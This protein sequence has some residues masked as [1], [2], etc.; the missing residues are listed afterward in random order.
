MWD[1]HC[2]TKLYRK[3]V[4]NRI[5]WAFLADYY[6]HRPALNAAFHISCW[7]SDDPW[8]LET[9]ASEKCLSRERQR[10]LG[11]KRNHSTN[12]FYQELWE[13]SATRVQSASSGILH[14][15]TLTYLGGL[16][17]EDVMIR[18]PGNSSTNPDIPQGPPWN[19]QGI[20]SRTSTENISTMTLETLPVLLHSGGSHTNSEEC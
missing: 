1:L 9:S 14:S 12:D 20:S 6:F 16:Q 13:V 8:K 15:H 2:V 4:Y 7:G 18:T 19:T 3:S 17:R 5:S 11:D 10:D